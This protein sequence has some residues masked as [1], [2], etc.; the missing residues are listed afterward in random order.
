MLGDPFEA[1]GN[2]IRVLRPHGGED[3]QDDEIERPLEQFD[4]AR[5]FTRHP[6]RSL[7]RFY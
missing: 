4:A 1:G 3:A 2:A 6:S 7:P 5:L